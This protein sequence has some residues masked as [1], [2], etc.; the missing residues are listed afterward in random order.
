L[1]R[2]ASINSTGSA[3][4]RAPGFGVV[5]RLPSGELSYACDGLLGLG[6][7]D[8]D[9]TLV[10]RDDGKF[11]LGAADRALRIVTAD[12]CTWRVP[13][14]WPEG[15]GVSV[16]TVARDVPGLYFAISEEP[17]P[18]LYR[19]VDA[20]ESWQLQA[21]LE[22]GSAI[23]AMRVTQQPN[24]PARVYITRPNATGRTLLLASNNDGTTFA[25]VEYAADL[26]LIDV[27]RGLPDQLWLLSPRPESGDVAILRGPVSAPTF[28][29]MHRVRFFGGIAVDDATNT[30]WIADEAGAL[31]RSSDGGDNFAPVQTALA[32]ACLVHAD[33]RLWACTA[34]TN[35]ERALAVSDDRGETFVDAFTFA[36]VDRLA[37]CQSPVDADEVC[38][39]A[40]S[41][42]QR[43][44]LDVPQTDASSDAGAEPDASRQPRRSTGCQVTFGTRCDPWWFAIGAALVSIYGARRLRAPR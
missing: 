37:A 44:V 17:S 39:S 34:G 23:T 28:E 19:S 15:V 32:V 1:A 35:D 41:E 42:W 6:A 8:Q 16:M 36:Q 27:A 22:T 12:G 25:S 11:L 21:Q 13:N 9:A 2:A 30:V 18:S 43:D 33:G 3:I 24:E 40:W 4:V 7:D 10:V 31:V 38:A 29:T 5:L 26:T 20:G 14:G